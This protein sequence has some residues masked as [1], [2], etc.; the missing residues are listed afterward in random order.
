MT[1]NESQS[2]VFQTSFQK[3]GKARPTSL[4]AKVIYSNWQQDGI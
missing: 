3:I 2:K 4:V 1:K